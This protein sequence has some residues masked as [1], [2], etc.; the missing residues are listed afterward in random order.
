M[1]INN[2]AG[3]F[4]HGHFRFKDTGEPFRGT[5]QRIELAGEVKFYDGSGREIIPAAE[6]EPQPLTEAEL[7]Y[8]GSWKKQ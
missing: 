4:R 6:K 7:F 5:P 1:Q 8:N 2:G 3:W